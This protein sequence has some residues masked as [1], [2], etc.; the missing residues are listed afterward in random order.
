[1]SPLEGRV[2]LYQTIGLFASPAAAAL[3]VCV[4]LALK[5]GSLSALAQSCTIVLVCTP[6][7]CVGTW[8][9]M[10]VENTDVVCCASQRLPSDGTSLLIGPSVNDVAHS[11]ELFGPMTKQI[12]WVG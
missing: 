10:Q 8:R 5:Q 3:P 12:H 11:T 7:S 2:S 4:L 6:I 1:M 9:L